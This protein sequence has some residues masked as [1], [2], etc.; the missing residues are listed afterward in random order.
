MG[1]P[2]I[3]VSIN[4]RLNAWGFL[5]SKEVR[6]EGG[7]N[8]GLRDQRLAFQWVNQN[9][10]YFGGDSSQVTIAGESGTLFYKFITFF[11]INIGKTA[12]ATCEF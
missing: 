1:N 7:T 5:V 3:G 2:M 6:A 8:N 12:G 4:Y 10:G 11:R 9:I